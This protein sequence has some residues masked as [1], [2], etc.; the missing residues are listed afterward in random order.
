[1]RLKLDN[2]AAVLKDTV[3]KD[4]RFYGAEFLNDPRGMLRNI[5][6]GR[7]KYQ[8]KIPINDSMLLKDIHKIQKRS[9]EDIHKEQQ[10]KFRPKK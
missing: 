8:N 2:E 5:R 1:M 7:L 4:K 10:K 9:L 3:E 6:N